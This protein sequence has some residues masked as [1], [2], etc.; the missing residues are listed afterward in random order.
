MHTRKLAHSCVHTII[1]TQA[2]GDGDSE[3]SF[4]DEENFGGDI[5]KRVDKQKHKEGEGNKTEKK[6]CEHPKDFHDEGEMAMR[7][8]V[9]PACFVV[10]P[11]CVLSDRPSSCV[12]VAVFRV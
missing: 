9:L 6:E 11:A 3:N 5:E 2:E 10:R 8:C 12:C 7:L 4:L 1:Q